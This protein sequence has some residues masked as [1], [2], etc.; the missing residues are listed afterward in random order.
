MQQFP[1]RRVLVVAILA[2]VSA[3]VFLA[4]AMS[5]SGQSDPPPTPTPTPLFEPTPGLVD[6]PPIIGDASVMSWLYLPSIIS[7]Y[8]PPIIGE[9]LPPTTPTQA[10]IVITPAPMMT[11]SATPS[12]TPTAEPSATPFIVTPTVALVDVPLFEFSN[13][14][15][16]GVWAHVAVCNHTWGE[17]LATVVVTATLRS[18]G[19][20]SQT[21]PGAP[22]AVE[23]GNCAHLY[24]ILP[25]SGKWSTAAVAVS[26][27]E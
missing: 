17:V 3:A 18:G 26:V 22:V 12:A 4:L 5:A 1:T 16:D 7:T 24:E 23:S 2:V 21:W 15:Y 20:E 25:A 19:E 13:A 14:A 9:P 8:R 6:E 27:G 11:P 10:P